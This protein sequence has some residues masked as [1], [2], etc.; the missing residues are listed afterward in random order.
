MAG[1]KYNNGVWE[2]GTDAIRDAYQCDTPGQ[3]V[4]AF[5]R[6]NQ[7]NKKEGA[8]KHF[9]QVFVNPLKGYPYNEAIKVTEKK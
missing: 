7:K 2:Q 6:E 4:E 1:N 5:I 3:K 9:N 8:K